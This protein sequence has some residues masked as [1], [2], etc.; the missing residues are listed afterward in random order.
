M[1]QIQRLLGPDPDQRLYF[2]RTELVELSEMAERGDGQEHSPITA[3]VLEIPGVIFTVIKPY[4]VVVIKAP[5]FSWEELEPSI[6]RLLTAFNAGE[7]ALQGPPEP[8]GG[9]NP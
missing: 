3:A 4:S 6:L 9:I 2:S 8:L 7:G 5:P 1:V